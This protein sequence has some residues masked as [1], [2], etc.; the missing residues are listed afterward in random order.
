MQ[1]F[2]IFF[3]RPVEFGIS[4]AITVTML[5]IL[6]R[7]AMSAEGPNGLSRFMTKPTSKGLSVV[8]CGAFTMG[9][10]REPTN[11]VT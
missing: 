10:S 9:R 8:G 3:N 6:L 11:P 7:S 4:I 5:L 1:L 2:T